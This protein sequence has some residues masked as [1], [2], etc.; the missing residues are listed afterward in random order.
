MAQSCCNAVGSFIIYKELSLTCHCKDDLQ[1]C[2]PTTLGRKLGL[3]EVKH[4][5][6]SYTANLWQN[7]ALNS[8]LLSLSQASWCSPYQV[9]SP[10]FTGT[11]LH[12]RDCDHVSSPTNTG[13]D[14][15]FVPHIAQSFQVASKQEMQSLPSETLTI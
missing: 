10:T 5:A 11:P 14:A 12:R 9:A 15:H 3:V 2:P 4:Q 6:R 8:C 13:L 7:Q 1:D